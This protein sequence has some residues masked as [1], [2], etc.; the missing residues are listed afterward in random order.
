MYKSIGRDVT[1]WQWNVERAKYHCWLTH[2]AGEPIR[3]GRMGTHCIRSTKHD[4]ELVVALAKVPPPIQSQEQRH[5]IWRVLNRCA[6][7]F[8]V[9]WTVVMHSAA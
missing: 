4:T 6:R 2:F 7:G 9:T 5:S 3:F 1:T 8:A